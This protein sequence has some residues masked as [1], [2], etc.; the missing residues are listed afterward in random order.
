MSLHLNNSVAFT[1]EYYYSKN[2]DVN[3]KINIKKAYIINDSLITVLLKDDQYSKL[4]DLSDEGHELIL[5]SNFYFIIK[6]DRSKNKV[7]TNLLPVF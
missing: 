7:Y 6:Y 1:V 4:K 5:G 2:P 3:N